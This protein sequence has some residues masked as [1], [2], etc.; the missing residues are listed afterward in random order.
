MLLFRSE[1]NVKQWCAMRGLPV[2]PLL[3]LEQQWHLATT[4]YGNRLT[5]DSR[6]P[7]PE[8]ITEIFA[9]IGLEGKFWDPKAAG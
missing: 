1:E 4:W 8:E 9:Q 3:N 5:I 7:A 2:R 6:R